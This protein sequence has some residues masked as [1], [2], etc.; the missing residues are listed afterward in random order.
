V[1][2][3][4]MLVLRASERSTFVCSS[5]E[6]DSFFR[7]IW[8]RPSQ[9]IIRVTKAPK[10]PGSQADIGSRQVHNKADLT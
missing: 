5:G 9:V 3:G 2:T 8:P 4:W 7:P 10:L 1:E 6:P